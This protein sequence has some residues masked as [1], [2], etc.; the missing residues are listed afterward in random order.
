VLLHCKFYLGLYV[1]LDRADEDIFNALVEKM[2]ILTPTHFVF[3]L[4]KTPRF[5][6]SSYDNWS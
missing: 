1:S 4:I 5:F 6:L 3:E 2:E